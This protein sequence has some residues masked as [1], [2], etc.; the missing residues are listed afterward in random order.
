V[1]L[2]IKE[3]GAPYVVFLLQELERMNKILATMRADLQ[4]LELGLSGALNISDSMDALINSLFVNMV[5]PAWLKICGQIGPTGTYNRK[6]LTGWWADLQL[7]WKQLEEWAAPSKPLE[8]CPPSVWIAGTFNPMGYVT[9]CLQVTAR[10]QNHSLDSMRVQMEVTKIVDSLAVEAQPDVGT[11]VHGLFMEGAQW[12]LEED[13]ITESKPKELYPTMPVIHII[14]LT[15]DEINTAG[16]YQ[17]PIFVTTIRG[18]TFV[19]AGPLRTKVPAI[20][21]TL[22]GV[23]LVMQPD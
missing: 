13:C 1:K 6:S 15:V 8:V 21:W 17:C 10:A 11:Y 23:A 4:E 20:K 19:F 2:R 16:F 18:P 9:A 5:P 12:D 7:R 22:A 3:K 14:A